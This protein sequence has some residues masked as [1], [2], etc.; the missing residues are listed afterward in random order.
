M[1]FSQGVVI[2][3]RGRLE[4]SVLLAVLV[5][6]MAAGPVLAAA[7][8]TISS[9]SPNTGANNN[10]NLSITNL[11]GSNFQTDA[12]VKLTKTGQADIEAT[13]ENRVSS[14]KITC[15]LNLAG[16]LA[17]QWNVVVTN[18]DAKTDTLANGFTITA[19]LTVT[20]ISPATGVNTGSVNISDLTGTNFASGATVKLQKSGQ[21]DIAATG[22]SVVSATKITCTLS[23]SG[24][25]AGAWDVVVTN[26]NGGNGML[27]GGFTITNPAP[28]VTGIAPSSG[29]NNG[30]VSITD[31]AGTGFLTGAAVKLHK[32][33]QTDIAATGVSVV[34]ASKITCTLGLSGKA[35]GA[36]DVVVTNSDAQS[37]TLS[38]GFTIVNPAPTV[39]GITPNSGTNTGSVSITNLA[40]TNFLAGAGVK[41]QRSGQP[42][43][44]ATSVVRS[45]STKITCTLNLAGAAAGGWDVVVTNPDG[46]SGTLPAG[47]TVFDNPPPT[48]TGITPSSGTNDG[49]VSITNLAGTGFLPGATVR[50]QK[51]GQTSITASDVVPLTSTQITCVLNLTGAVTGAWDVVVTNTDG[52]SGTKTGAFTINDP[53]PTVTSITPASGTNNGVTVPGYVLIGTGFRTGAA[54]TLT[55]TG[56]T[57]IAASAEN[58]LSDTEMTCSLQIATS[59]QAG[60]WNVVVT[61]TGGTGTLANGF[62]V[63][64]PVPTVTSITPNT[65]ANNNA[66]LS[67]TNLAGTGFLAGATVKLQKSGQ[68][69]INATNVVVVTSIKITCTLNLTD[70]A[71]GAW[72]VVMT[73]PDGQSAVNKPS[74]AITN[75][76]AAPTVT[77]I[78]PS[79]GATGTSASI[80][81]LSGTG[82]RAGATVKL[83]KSG[84]TAIAATNVVVV[85]GTQITCSVD[86]AGAATGAWDVVVTNTDGQSGTLAGG[87]TI[88]DLVPTVTSITPN[89]GVN[90]G[91]VSITNLAGTGFLSGASVKLRKTGQTDLAASGVSVV[92]TTQ[93]TC[94]LNLAGTAVGAWDVVVTNPNGQSGTLAGGFTVTDSGL[95]GPTISSITRTGAVVNWTTTTALSSNVGYGTSPQANYAAYPNHAFGPGGATYHAVTLAGLLP[96]TTYYLC[97]RSE[98]GGGQGIESGT[99]SFTTSTLLQP[100][101]AYSGSTTGTTA[102]GENVTLAATLTQGAGLSG[103]TISFVCGNCAQTATTDANGVASI[104]VPVAR[105]GAGAHTVYCK[106]GGD[107]T[108]LPASA[109]GGLNLAGVAGATI[110]RGNG[111]FNKGGDRTQRCTFS[112]RFNVDLVAGWLTFTDMRTQKTISAEVVKSIVLTPD[113]N[114]GPQATVVCG[115]N[116]EY[117]LVVDVNTRA[118]SITEGPPGS[119]SYSS[120]GQAKGQIAI[121][122]EMGQ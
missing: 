69:D 117:T 97:V 37:G 119:P 12:Q 65:G 35:T 87:F 9:I 118:V 23:L 27:A 91:T 15:T 20:G 32:T 80:T 83:Q 46:G 113:P 45:S 62:T 74:F 50:L 16:K 40:G 114:T 73:N 41:L 68:P 90:G 98:D 78:T 84:E 86:L 107:A 34:S 31:L 21:S 13:N 96:N 51:S 106:F 17:G 66:A 56:Q 14:S 94:S 109:T 1:G 121:G 111:Y 92:S 71:A 42:D 101:L 36:W 95:R 44:T 88:A 59:K 58:V 72:A 100:T 75:A 85:S 18:P 82:F 81:D 53:V 22:V 64:N 19:A 104:Q 8:P 26:A 93:I 43:I 103:K 67:I 52:Q 99:V 33:G 38:G 76:Y 105:L 25:A 54:V 89:S 30:S 29:A 112:F 47:F 63:N 4:V 48:V 122:E 3:C 108:Y 110:L 55:K 39:T 102:P 6:L 5:V 7:A 28:T 10:S 70:K 11:A 77:G 60:L 49:S 57:A 61:T 120:S 116:D 24:A 79:S 2:R 115:P